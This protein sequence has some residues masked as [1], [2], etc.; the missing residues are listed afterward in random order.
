MSQIRRRHI[1]NNGARCPYIT[2]GLIFHLDGA[3]A[4]QDKWV[5]RIGKIPFNLVNTSKTDDGGVMFTGS[6]SY[7]NYAAG[8]TFPLAN[9]TLEIVYYATS[10]IA[11]THL[12]T[13]N[14]DGSI[15]FGCTVQNVVVISNSNNANSKIYYVPIV[16]RHSVS[17]NKNNG[18]AD[19]NALSVY[20]GTDCWY[21][22]S[23]GTYIGCRTSGENYFSGVI[24]QIRVYNRIL[25]EEEILFNQ[26]VDY[27]R[28]IDSKMSVDCVKG[29]YVHNGG[30]LNLDADSFYTNGIFVKAGQV[31]KLKGHVGAIMAAVYSID[32]NTDVRTPLVF[33]NGSGQYK[34]YTYTAQQ[35]CYIG[36]CAK[37]T[38][39]DATIFT[40]D[41]KI[42]TLNNY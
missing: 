6:R 21:L 41:G 27:T 4:T 5:D 16:D 28:Y 15:A 8:L 34:T 38:Y 25:T 39:S 40:I 36:I 17:V 26:A 33:G 19:G 35:D 11:S 22:R 24:Y 3:D 7:G 12:F 37:Y 1:G 9:C 32:Q 13:P 18:Y 10:S 2:D 31:V 42:V 20:S 30:T 23:G 29:I 14:T